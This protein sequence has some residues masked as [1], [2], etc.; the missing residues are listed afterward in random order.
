MYQFCGNCYQQLAAVKLLELFSLQCSWTT[1]YVTVFAWCVPTAGELRGNFRCTLLSCCP[2]RCLQMAIRAVTASPQTPRR[3]NWPS[4]HGRSGA[5]PPFPVSRCRLQTNIEWRFRKEAFRNSNP[6]RGQLDGPISPPLSMGCCSSLSDVKR[7]SLV[8]HP[9]AATKDSES[10][11]RIQSA[12]LL[13]DAGSAV[14]GQWPEA[15]TTSGVSPHSNEPLYLLTFTEYFDDSLEI[16]LCIEL[17]LLVTGGI[18]K[19]APPWCHPS[20][21]SRPDATWTEDDAKRGAAAYHLP[22]LILPLASMWL[23]CRHLDPCSRD[24]RHTVGL[25]GRQSSQGYQ[26]SADCRGL[27]FRLH[28][29][30]AWVKD[31]M[32]DDRCRFV[33]TAAWQTLA[34]IMGEL[35]H[36]HAMTKRFREIIAG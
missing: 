12:V 4:C 22:F 6:L 23:R 25:V 33:L 29:W 20:L 34:T 3:L 36:M 18:D 26:C 30:S 35:L 31:G 7:R 1:V 11:C 32:V 27:P 28:Q 5:A 14:V 10:P 17:P 8:D 24:N 13:Q 9:A 15:D 21:F 2:D 19:A 16:Q